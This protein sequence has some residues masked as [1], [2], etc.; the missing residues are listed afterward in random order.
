MRNQCILE[1]SFLSL[2]SFEDLINDLLTRVYLRARVMIFNAMHFQ[3]YFSYTVVVSF[4][5]GRNRNTHRKPQTCHKSLTEFIDYGVSSTPRQERD[6]NP[7][8]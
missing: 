8:R 2:A 7:Q 4:I 5:G 3:Q 6:A 1:L